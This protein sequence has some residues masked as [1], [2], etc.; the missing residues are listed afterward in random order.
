[1]PSRAALLAHRIKPGLPAV[2]AVAILTLVLL[3]NFA[4]ADDIGTQIANFIFKPFRTGLAIATAQT[5]SE[6]GQQA[7]RG[8]E[9]INASIR[10]AGNGISTTQ[11]NV[12]MDGFA[13]V[14]IAVTQGIMPICYTV[15]GIVFAIRM[16]KALQEPDNGPGNVPYIEK[17]AWLWIKFCL[18]KLVM[19]NSVGITIGVFN[20]IMRIVGIV[21]ATG[22][23]NSPSNLDF[24]TVKDNILHALESNDSLFDA[25]PVGGIL[26]SG[27]LGLVA[28]LGS[29][30]LKV[31]VFISTY[32][33]WAQVWI[34]LCFAP[35]FFSFAGL[36]E[37]KGMFCSY[38]KTM[39]GLALAFAMTAILLKALAPVLYSFATTGNGDVMLGILGV[40]FVFIFALMKVGS[41][42]RDL[43]GG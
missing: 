13:N 38:L 3:P 17:F 9:Y 14:V 24:N 25:I 16:I 11:S 27:L 39:A 8:F 41:W 43:I 35:L 31:V 29:M 15:L 12:P 5:I 37:T 42:S 30:F 40:E 32:G 22:Y 7:D 33:R 36:D 10:T 21:G 34:C 1:M 6:L 20:E 23:A 28:Y 4:F 19:D 18:L 2:L 26:I